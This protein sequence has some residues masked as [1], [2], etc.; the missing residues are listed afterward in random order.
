[1]TRQLSKRELRKQEAQLKAAAEAEKAPQDTPKQWKKP[2]SYGTV[3]S[4][5]RRLLV[6]EGDW[7]GFTR[8]GFKAAPSCTDVKEVLPIPS[9]C[10]TTSGAKKVSSSR[11]LSGLPA[12]RKNYLLRKASC[13]QSKRRKRRIK[14]NR[15]RKKANKKVIYITFL[16]TTVK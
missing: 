9:G 14:R 8:I 15:A 7:D 2:P 13:K 3:K 10:M 5:M 11:K 16:D 6:H 4:R 1:M 12:P